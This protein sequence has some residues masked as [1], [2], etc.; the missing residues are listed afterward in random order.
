MT[1]ESYDPVDSG[2]IEIVLNP[3]GFVDDDF[4]LEVT[5][6]SNADPNITV[7]DLNKIDHSVE[8]FDPSTMPVD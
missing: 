4:D 1:W 7:F 8:S 5:A 2:V 6:N 3:N